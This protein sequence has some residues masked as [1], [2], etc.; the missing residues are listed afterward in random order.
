MREDTSD[1]SVT[2]SIGIDRRNGR[3]PR[4]LR[5]RLRKERSALL[6]MSGPLEDGLASESDPIDCSLRLRMQ[7]GGL[8]FQANSDLGDSK[9]QKVFDLRWKAPESNKTEHITL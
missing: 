4:S 6:S 7:R 1:T 5:L 2:K 9:D 3:S 8:E